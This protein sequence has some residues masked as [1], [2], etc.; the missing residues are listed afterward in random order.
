MKTIGISDET[1]KELMGL[2]IECGEKTAEGLIEKMLVEYKKQ[3]LLEAG[4]AFRE[5]MK[6]GKMRLGDVIKRSEKIRE[7]IYAE[8]FE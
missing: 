2:K 4:K 6:K 1:H 3:K 7:G 8:W 5:G